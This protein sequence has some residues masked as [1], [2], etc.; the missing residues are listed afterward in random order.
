LPPANYANAKALGQISKLFS[1]IPVKIDEHEF[2]Q[3]ELCFSLASV[4]S[5]MDRIDEK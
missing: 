4:E 1:K 3:G 5:S 2:R